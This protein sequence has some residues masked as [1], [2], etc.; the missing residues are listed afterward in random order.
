MIFWI[1]V[2]LALISGVLFACANDCD[3]IDFFG[4]LLI[5]N[6][7]VSIIVLAVVI[8]CNAD[9]DGTAASLDAQRESLVY[10][11]E[12]DIYEND[13]D[14]GKRELMV[15]IQTWNSDLAYHKEVQ[16][17]FWIGIFIP[18]IY[19]RFEPIDIYN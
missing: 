19:D 3:W 14:L 13:N 5:V 10:Q 11:Y 1:F 8:V 4:F 12:N 2:I 7:M 15:E 6:I 16:N 9:A 17:N 18:N